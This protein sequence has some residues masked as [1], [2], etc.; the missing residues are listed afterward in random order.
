MRTKSASVAAL[1]ALALTVSACGG[2]GGEEQE[3]SGE[4]IIWADDIRTPVLEEFTKDFEKTTGVEVKVEEHADELREDY[5]TATE[6][7][8]GP[9][10]VLG[11]HDWIGDYVRNG[12]IAPVQLSDDQIASLAP[13]SVDAVT[14]EDQL[15]GVPY[16]MENLALLRNAELAP[17][18]PASFEEMVDVGSDLVD[19]G[20]TKEALTT[21]VGVDGDPYHAYPMFTSMGG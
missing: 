15:Y 20:K 8:Q 1:A 4:L 6:Q 3:F 12:A 2:G 17:E 14:V 7:D 11:A 13:E 16:G 10:I 18:E 21:A 9:D 19:D 5:L